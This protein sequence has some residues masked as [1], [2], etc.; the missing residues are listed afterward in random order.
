MLFLFKNAGR[1]YIQF[2][3]IYC[4]TEA[5]QKNS[6]YVRH[7]AQK[8]GHQQPFCVFKQ[9]LPEKDLHRSKNVVML[10]IPI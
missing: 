9:K 10:Y 5:K 6:K 3:V 1:L 8:I 2:C 7:K 4:L